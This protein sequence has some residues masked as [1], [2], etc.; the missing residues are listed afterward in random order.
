MTY[1]RPVK[2][3]Q[4]IW[5][6]SRLSYNDLEWSRMHIDNCRRWLYIYIYIQSGTPNKQESTEAKSK[7]GGYFGDSYKVPLNAP[8]CLLPCQTLGKVSCLLRVLLFVGK[9]LGTEVQGRFFSPASSW[10]LRPALLYLCCG[11]CPKKGFPTTNFANFSPQSYPVM[12]WHL[13][14]GAVSRFIESAY[15]TWLRGLHA[16]ACWK[17]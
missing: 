7:A 2:G 16:Y 13:N 11:F 4:S 5:Y 17:K 12:F 14:E 3:G 8:I 9:G 6:C 10:V 1:M 15:C